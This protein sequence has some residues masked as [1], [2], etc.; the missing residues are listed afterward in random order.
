MDTLLTMDESGVHIASPEIAEK[1]S[2]KNISASLITGLEEC[3]AKW[4]ANTFAIDQIVET[5][6]DNPLTRGTLFHSVMEDFFAEP[7]E[8]R[9]KKRMKSVINE[10]LQ[11]PDFEHFATNRDA[12]MWL[13]DAI[14][15]YYA[16]GGKPEKVNVA[17]FD[18]KH[19]EKSGLEYFVK[20]EVGD[21][22]RK[23]LGFVDRI[24][25][26]P[27]DTSKRIV[28]DWKSGAKAKKWNGKLNAKEGI[29]EQRQ[30]M[31]YSMLLEDD[32]FEISAA[33][34]IYPVAREVVNVELQNEKLR[35]KVIEDVERT[36]AQLDHLEETN[37]FEYTPSFLCAFCPLA[38]ICPAAQIKM[39][40]KLK[41][42][43]QSQP[44]P[45]ELAE[46]IEL[47]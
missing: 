5:E 43:Y 1:L 40:G 45:E 35:E 18:T 14:N 31:I 13:R 10:T 46:G 15:G 6:L 11:K 16:M 32:G 39:V 38:K 12:V 29:P 24:I 3:A 26:D 7:P 47:L 20:G 44:D 17:K 34:L 2:K 41:D 37:T 28:E 8:K 9:T 30:Q 23:V 25:V 36:D 27:R 42:G 22:K 4:V 33:R 19:G 21:S